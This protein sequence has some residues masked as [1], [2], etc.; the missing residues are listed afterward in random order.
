MLDVQLQLIVWNSF[1]QQFNGGDYS[2]AVCM[3]AKYDN[4]ITSND[5][6]MPD[7]DNT[8]LYYGDDSL[9]MRAIYLNYFDMVDTTNRDMIN[10]TNR[11]KELI[12]NA[13]K[14][15]MIEQQKEEVNT[16]EIKERALLR[17]QTMRFS[18]TQMAPKQLKL[19]NDLWCQK[20][21]GIL[22]T[23]Y[24]KFPISAEHILCSIRD[25]NA[26][27][28]VL[29][30]G[31]QTLID[32]QNQINAD[33]A[34]MDRMIGD[35]QNEIQIQN[36]FSMFEEQIEF[37][38]VISNSIANLTNMRMK[39]LHKWYVI[40]NESLMSRIQ[41]ELRIY[42]DD[43]TVDINLAPNQY[44]QRLSSDFPQ[45]EMDDL[46]TIMLRL[47]KHW[48]HI[49]KHPK[50][51]Y[52]DAK[53]Y[54]EQMQMR[55][56]RCISDMKKASKR[57]KKRSQ[58]FQKP[59][60][61]FQQ[62]CIDEMLKMD[63]LMPDFIIDADRIAALRHPIQI[64]TNDPK[65]DAS[66]TFTKW[67]TYFTALW[68]RLF[69]NLAIEAPILICDGF[70]YYLTAEQRQQIYRFLRRVA[71]ERQIQIVLMSRNSV[72]VLRNDEVFLMFHT[73]RH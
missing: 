60:E 16:L 4:V 34:E 40:R 71:Y 41:I 24:R 57:L 55:K 5:W 70:D 9:E 25:G 42:H 72:S 37:H 50:I 63:F 31:I 3:R 45:F 59:F 48:F 62:I 22:G 10:I 32:E 26:W 15:Q 49:G 11:L 12:T 36:I 18:A 33:H 53:D 38:N 19:L 46:K 65:Q 23:V 61:H 20:K 56:N 13:K 28:N 44:K 67:N 14:N 17:G 68:I 2:G 43:E 6:P 27:N 8:R 64:I 54:Y 66:F 7:I 29:Q 73:V 51:F 58:T 47:Q 52:F 21:N 69:L 35:L 39:Q 30:S 1:V